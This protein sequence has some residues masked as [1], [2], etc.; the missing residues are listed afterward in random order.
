MKNANYP[1][2]LAGSLEEWDDFL[3]GCLPSKVRNAG[4]LTDFKGMHFYPSSRIGT[5]I[6]WK[7]GVIMRSHYLPKVTKKYLFW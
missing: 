2:P 3:H 5:R 7:T 6:G 4:F 1:L